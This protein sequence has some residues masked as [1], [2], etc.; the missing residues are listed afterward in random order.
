MATDTLELVT[1]QANASGKSATEA[2]DHGRQAL[3]EAIIAAEKVFVE[4]A[5]R[6]DKLF[7]ESERT[8]KDN[9]ER[10]REQAKTYGETAGQSVDEA[11]RYVRSSLWFCRRRRGDRRLSVVGGACGAFALSG[12][13]WR[14][15]AYRA[16]IGDLSFAAGG[17][18]CPR[19]RTKI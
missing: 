17:R 16:G 8:L 12:L 11:Q 5:K 3:N 7:R 10:L 14:G 6:A 4:G 9:V 18:F 1:E 19:R 15:G 2:V 13:G